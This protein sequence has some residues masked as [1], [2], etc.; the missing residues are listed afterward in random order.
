MK[1]PKIDSATIWI[2]APSI[3]GSD[4]CFD[5]HGSTPFCRSSAVVPCLAAGLAVGV[6]AN[7]LAG[8]DV[9]FHLHGRKPFQKVWL[10]SYLCRRRQST[11]FSQAFSRPKEEPN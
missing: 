7:A 5:V 9:C 3:A 11:D 4:S 1:A 2:D 8:L 10:V 6:C